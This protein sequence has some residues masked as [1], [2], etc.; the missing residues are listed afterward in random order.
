[1][2]GDEK[3]RN[4][5]TQTTHWERHSCR[6]SY[7]DLRAANTSP[8]APEYLESGTDYS[9]VRQVLANRITHTTQRFVSFSPQ[10]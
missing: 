8:H 5:E 1:K 4:N 9:P 3:K 6:K 2:R 10:K 7:R